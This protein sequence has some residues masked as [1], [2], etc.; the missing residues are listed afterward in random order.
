MHTVDTCRQRLE[1]IKSNLVPNDF[2]D[3]PSDV[4]LALQKDAL[5]KE[6][7]SESVYKKFADIALHVES[8]CEDEQ[9]AEASMYF[10]SL[11]RLFF[12]IQFS[13]SLD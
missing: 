4:L 3:V 5:V 8:L 12:S 13:E 1:A 10:D 7:S 2:D 6:R 9:Y 11:E